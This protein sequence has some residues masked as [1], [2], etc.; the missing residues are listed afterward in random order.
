MMN[1]L[2]DERAEKGL[3]FLA[4][5]DEQA[6]DLKVEAQRLEDEIKAVKAAIFQRVE[7]GAELR[8]A[9]AE[10]H[11]STVEARNK[12]YAALMKHEHM[13]NRRRTEERITD[14]WRSVN[15]NRRQGQ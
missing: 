4:T 6:A 11:E 7:G 2:T 1:S 8:K 10:T 12:Y 5:T 14:L 3:H 13:T 15:A 9:M